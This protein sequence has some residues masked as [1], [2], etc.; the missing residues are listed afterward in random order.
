M[1]RVASREMRAEVNGEVGDGGRRWETVEA[2]S[3]ATRS[4]ANLKDEDENGEVQRCTGR[5]GFSFMSR[6]SRSHLVC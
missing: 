6:A 1:V 5:K 3:R 2:S 4:T